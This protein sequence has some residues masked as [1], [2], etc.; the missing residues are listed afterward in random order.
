MGRKRTKPLV[1]RN[2]PLI[3]A[4]GV[5]DE[6]RRRSTSCIV[7]M[8]LGKDSIV[9]LDLLYEKFDRIVCVFMY[10]VKG[11]EHIQRWIDWLRARYP[12]IEFEQ[13]P[14]WNLTYNLRNG[15][16]CVPNPNVRVLNLSMVVKSLKSRFGIDY[17]FFGMKKADSMN[18]ALMLKSYHEEQYIHGGNCYPLA[19]FTQKQILQY[20]KHHHLPMPIMY[21]RAL[22]TGKA[23]VGNASGGLS[24]DIDCFAWLQKYAPQDLE[25]I[26]KVF[27][28]SR[29]ILYRYNQSHGETHENR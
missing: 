3:V 2:N 13:I 12:R 28:Q 11:L 15:V 21:A 6:V 26:Y 27:P 19:D 8:S 14:H 10:L 1:V 5:I 7:M 18:R 24:L 25:L 16:Y 17:V 9:T 4:N 23:E 20:M 29:V 22:R